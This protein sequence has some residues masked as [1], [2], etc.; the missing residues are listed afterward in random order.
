M[1]ILWIT[2]QSGIK[3]LTR[4][5][6]RVWSRYVCIESCFLRTVFSIYHQLFFCLQSFS[7]LH[8]FM[9]LANCMIWNIDRFR[10]ISPMVLGYPIRYWP[11]NISQYWGWYCWYGQYHRWQSILMILILKTIGRYRFRYWHFKPW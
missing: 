4:I 11:Y 1:V 5:L 9:L 10:Y 3:R 2:L 6:H 8:H 7:V